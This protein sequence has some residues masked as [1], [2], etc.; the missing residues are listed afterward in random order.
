MRAAA[1]R[2]SAPRSRPAATAILAEIDRPGRPSPDDVE[3]LSEHA[4]TIAALGLARRAAGVVRRWREQ[5]PRDPQLRLL[6]ALFLVF[7]SPTT[8]ATLLQ[9]ASAG[10]PAVAELAVVAH[11]F[12]GEIDRAIEL[13]NA[14]GWF[15]R[16]RVGDARGIFHGA[17]ALVVAGRF[18]EAQQHIEAWK[19]G[20]GR[21]HPEA[22]QL[23]LRAEA[24]VASFRHQFDRE[25][26]LLEEALAIADQH[27]LATARA[28]TEPLLAMA[29]ARV[30]DRDRAHALIR[31]WSAT[32]ISDPGPQGY[33]DLAQL[34]IGLLDGEPARA[35]QAGRRAL[36]FANATGHAVLACHIR[37]Y[38]VFAASRAQLPGA[39][40]EFAAHVHRHQ[41]PVYL[42]RWRFLEAIVDRYPH[43]LR[44]VE[45]VERGWDRKESIALV[46][47]WMPR[48]SAR[49]ADLYWD[50]P[51]GCFFFHGRGPHALREH[52]VLRRLLEAVL[53]T[54]HLSLPLAECFAAVWG[55]RYDP[56][57]HENKIH[58]AVHRLRTWLGTC[59]APPS[60]IRVR[61]GAVAVDPGLE[62]R[63]VEMPQRQLGPL[64]GDRL[65][66]R[67]LQCLPDD[68][69]VSM[70]Q[71]QSRLRISRSPLH[72]ALRELLARGEVVRTGRGPATSYRR[73]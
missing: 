19:R 50:R 61:D 24:R 21:R 39:L 69:T 48:P 46:R 54:E 16:G 15:C 43:G 68:G 62:V 18:E 67:V 11:F 63:I 7:C 66:D 47:L 26:A 27:G 14:Q 71:L 40:A 8:T 13:S 45:V 9:E 31:G 20:R 38:L 33:R 4:L 23:V 44:D 59:G 41:L 28:Y 2:P 51:C 55:Q 70:W 29:C 34:E 52:P 35:W 42:E 65:R 25:V 3:L 5:A 12:R 6:Q 10:D 36:G 17:W 60:I 57:I 32:A 72:R 56:L 58:V 22:Y 73:G 53:T 30:G 37:C 1:A 64:H 49:G